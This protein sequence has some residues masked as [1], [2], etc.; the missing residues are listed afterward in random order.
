[1]LTGIFGC[2]IPG[3]P[4]PPLNF[5]A[6]LLLQ[7][8]SLKPYAAKFLWLWALITFIVTVLDYLIPAIGTRR[9]GAGRWGVIGSFAGL[10][11]GIFLFPPWGLIIGPFAGAVTGELLA[12]KKGDVALKAGIGSF[13]GFIFGTVLKLCVSGMMSFYFFRALF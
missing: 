10:I 1:M 5:L 9:Y 3:L 8:S 2:I 13:L 7:F 11:I 6:L 4:G 12:G